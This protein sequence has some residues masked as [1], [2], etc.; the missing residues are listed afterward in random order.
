MTAKKSR[1]LNPIR[2]RAFPFGPGCSVLRIRS[3][4]LTG[5]LP[6]L[7]IANANNGMETA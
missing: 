3:V 1:S 7:H 4:R 5:L 2:L 6:T